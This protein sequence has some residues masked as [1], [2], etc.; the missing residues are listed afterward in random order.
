MFLVVVDKG[1]NHI[2]NLFYLQILRLFKPMMYRHC[3]TYLINIIAFL[4]G[5]RRLTTG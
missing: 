3:L 4:G 1:L 2:R 5:G